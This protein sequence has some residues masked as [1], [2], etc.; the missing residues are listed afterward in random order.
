MISRVAATRSSVDTRRSL[1]RFVA[2]PVM[3]P[4]RDG[5]CDLVQ[6]IE[7]PRQTP[8]SGLKPIVTAEE[9]IQELLS[10]IWPTNQNEYYEM[11]GSCGKKHGWAE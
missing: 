8:P 7:V 11:H 9:S 2:R 4:E 10:D 3:R 5:R 1:N 6:Q